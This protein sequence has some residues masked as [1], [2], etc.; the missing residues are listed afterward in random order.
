MFSHSPFCTNR[1]TPR[2]RTETD[3]HLLVSKLARTILWNIWILLFLNRKIVIYWFVPFHNNFFQ[4][5]IKNQ[6]RSMQMQAFSKC[7]HFRIVSS[8]TCWIILYIF[9]K[10][11]T[12]LNISN[13][14]RWKILLQIRI[15]IK[16][17]RMIA[18]SQLSVFC[19]K[20]WKWVEL[21]RFIFIHVSF[22]LCN[23]C[24]LL[25]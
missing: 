11:Y 19:G 22:A 5:F 18:L 14:F 16:T 7:F 6:L 25:T 21:T 8:C 2:S 24:F 1:Y 20:K 4:R 15:E 3:K 23:R 17:Y 9:F 10:N 12:L 13:L